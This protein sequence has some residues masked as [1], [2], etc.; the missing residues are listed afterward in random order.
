MELS[1]YNA[2]CL[3]CIKDTVKEHKEL[4]IAII[5][6]LFKY[7]IVCHSSIP[8]Y[9]RSDINKDL[10]G[11]GEYFGYKKIEGLFEDFNFLSNEEKEE[12]ILRLI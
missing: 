7:R 11:L 8:D 4:R 5:I 9:I 1:I 2:Y 6:D 12:I 10:L 3:S